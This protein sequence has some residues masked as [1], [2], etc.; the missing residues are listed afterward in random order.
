[1]ILILAI[2][3]LLIGFALGISYAH[4][5]QPVDLERENTKLRKE[6]EVLWNRI[7]QQ[8]DIDFTA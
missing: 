8:N 4:K 5:Q 6:N 7:N 2:F 1:M 3:S